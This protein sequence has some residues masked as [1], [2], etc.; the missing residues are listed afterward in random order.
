MTCPAADS[1]F[2]SRGSIASRVAELG[3][4]ITAHYSQLKGDLLLIG[5]LKGGFVFMADLVRQI[6][7]PHTVDFMILQSYHRGK[8]PKDIGDATPWTKLLYTPSRI[9]GRHQQDACHELLPPLSEDHRRAWRQ[10]P[11][12]RNRIRTSL[13][14]RHCH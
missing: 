8:A 14:G 3:Q 13:R 7:H 10:V 12:L 9:R 1:G 2:I 6:K 4:E 5:V 11:V